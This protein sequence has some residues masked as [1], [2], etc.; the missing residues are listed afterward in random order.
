MWSFFSRMWYLSLQTRYVQKAHTQLKFG[1]SQ[2]LQREAV[3]AERH[4][5]FDKRRRLW[6]YWYSTPGRSKGFKTRDQAIDAALLHPEPDACWSE[7]FA[8][9][10]L[11]ATQ[12]NSGMGRVVC[13]SKIHHLRFLFV[14]VSLLYD[15]MPGEIGAGVVI[16][17]IKCMTK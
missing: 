16:V 9:V 6:F 4:V 15:C 11:Q 17:I 7:M 3:A 5:S 12:E 1:T 14:W 8:W 13:E 2:F 10:V